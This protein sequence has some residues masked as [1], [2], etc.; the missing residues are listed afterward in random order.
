MFTLLQINVVVNWGSTGRIAEE[1]G[2]AAIAN[3]W[4]SFIAYGRNARPSQSK[5]IKIGSKWDMYSHILQTRLLGCHGLASKRATKKLISKIK[6]IKPDIIHLHNIHGYYLNYPLLMDYLSNA[7][8]PIIWTLHDCWSF[9]GH[10]SHF[11]FINCGKWKSKCSHCVQKKEYP[12]NW[13]DRSERNFMIKKKYFTSIEKMVLVPVSEWLQAFLKDSFLA[14]Y[15]S[16]C[17]HNGID[18]VTFFP[19]NVTPEWRQKVS[20]T[21]KYTVL[22]VTNIWNKRKGLNDFIQLRELLSCEYLIV[23]VGLTSKQLKLLPDGIMGISRTNSVE[24][25]AQYY[26]A[27]SV[28]VNPTWEDN[29][30]TTN[31]EALACGTPVITYR[32]GGSVEAITRENGIIVEQGDIV[33]LADA[34]QV[35]CSKGKDTYRKACRK[36]A[37]TYFNKEEC[38]QE[39]LDLYENLVFQKK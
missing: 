10:C 3:G 36:R 7:D 34:V 16:V 6:E 28:F 22:G 26:S 24:E 4:E 33:G 23:L 14:G 11:A 19:K 29:F 20:F 2:Q 5:L 17:I 39:Y 18:L 32:T 12:S 13:I 27:A 31:L 21:A 35:I 37:V 38:Y 9:T 30:P 15:P 8:I 1:I 25:L